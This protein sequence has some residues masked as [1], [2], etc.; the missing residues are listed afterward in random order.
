MKYEV[1]VQ[2][3]AESEIEAALLYLRDEA[4]LEIAD[5]WREELI[6][7]IATLEEMPSRCPTA[8]EDAFF[9]EEIRHLLI[10][11]YRVLFTVRGTKVHIL[12]V[13]HMARHSLTRSDE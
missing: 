5:R 1:L 10:R 11:P 6:E 13:R 2:P 8:P 4:S 12:H 7:A 3:G 9:T